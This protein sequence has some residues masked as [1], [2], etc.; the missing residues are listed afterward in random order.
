MY[1]AGV[2]MQD[3]KE[4][5]GHDDETE[6]TIYVHISIDTARR[7]LENHIANPLKYGD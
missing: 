6:T 3:I 4:I 1:E 2:T 5:L 7:F